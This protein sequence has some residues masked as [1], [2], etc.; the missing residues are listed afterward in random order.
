MERH[1]SLARAEDSLLVVVDPQEKLVNMIHNR[2]EV[3][4]TVS[5]LLRFSSIF[6]I[7]VVL[8]EH[9]PEGLGY[10]VDEIKRNLPY[11]QPIIKRIF[12]CFGVSEFREA[13]E[14][15]G[16]KRLL[17]TGIETHICICQTALDA[18][19][20]G[21]MVQVVADGVGTRFPRDHQTA[22]ARMRQAGAVI[23]TWE[24]LMYEIT[25]RA[26]TEEFKRVLELVK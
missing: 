9:Y 17:V 23:T 25:E 14:A 8:T 10:T 13:L 2:E 18:I 19:Q 21:Y 1:L 6:K 26:D 11:Y 16:R 4:K 5:L 7:P 24:A 12:S 3:V 22:I 15:S 20:H